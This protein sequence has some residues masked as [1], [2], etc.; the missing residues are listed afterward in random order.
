MHGRKLDDLKDAVGD[1]LDILLP[2]SGTT[3]KVRI[4]LA[5]FSAGVNAGAFAGAV[6][7]GRS[8]NGCVYERHNSAD[9]D[10]DVAPVGKAALKGNLDLP[11]AGA[12]SANAS[13]LPLSDD[14]DLLRRTVNAY[15]DRGSTAG[16]LGSAWAWYLLSPSWSAI[17]PGSSRP[18]SYNDGRTVKYAILMTDG[19]YNTV[20]GRSN[21]DH[22]STA[23]RSSTAAIE[24]CD[25][26]KAKGIVVYT[27]GFE[28]PSDAKDTLRACA[29]SRTKFYDASNGDQLRAAFRDIA[30]EINNLRLSQ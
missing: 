4:G 27:I 29:S 2:D 5:P 25:A 20:E 22:G 3:S 19:I 11:G 15:T 14:K 24:T 16:H 9:Q 28:A 30:S 8:S 21:G 12:C 7:N 1:L 18:A 17:F 6:S 26:M 13:V 23:R 10:T